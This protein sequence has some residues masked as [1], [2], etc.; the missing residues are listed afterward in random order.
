[1]GRGFLAPSSCASDI[2][3]SPVGSRRRPLPPSGSLPTRR[4]RDGRH[5]RDRE[6]ALA[7]E[8]LRTASFACTSEE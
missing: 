2:K 4:A 5:A 8:R 7:A 6:V 1:M 3:A